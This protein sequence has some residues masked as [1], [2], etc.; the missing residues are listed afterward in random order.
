MIADMVTAMPASYG[1]ISSRD[2]GDPQRAMLHYF[3]GIITFRQEVPDRRR[4]CDLMLVQGTPQDESAPAGNWIR[5]WEGNR[6]G[7]KQERY[8]LYRR[9]TAVV[10]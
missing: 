3:A 7:D 10:N 9:V 8:R 5:I 2:L 4:E 6:P 1:C